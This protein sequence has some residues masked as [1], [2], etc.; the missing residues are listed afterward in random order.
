MDYRIKSKATGTVYE[1][2][3]MECGDQIAIVLD[4]DG[5]E[6]GLTRAEVDLVFSK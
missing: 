3:R 2:V 1:V 5:A 6:F 4:R